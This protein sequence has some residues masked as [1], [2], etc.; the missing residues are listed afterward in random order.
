[1]T[2]PTCIRSSAV[3]QVQDVV[4]SRDFYVDKLGFSG[5]KLWGEPPCFCIVSRGTVTIML[6]QAREPCP[7]PVNQYWAAYVYIDDAEALH[8]E[9]KEAGAEIIRGPED[10]PY[11]CRDFDV[12]DPDGHL[13]AFG[14]DLQP[15]PD[16]PGL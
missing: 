4:R 16:G 8:R 12:R 6:D 1:M 3:L 15:G 14:Q 11:G 5:G 7:L 13:I 2:V 9:F 10:M